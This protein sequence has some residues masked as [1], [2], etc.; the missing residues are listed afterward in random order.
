MSSNYLE[1]CARIFKALGHPSRLKMVECL[2]DRERSVCQIREIIGSDIS[3]VSIHLK[4]LK[5]AGILQNERRGTA[6]YYS[7]RMKCIPI[8]LLSVGNFA[9]QILE[10]QID[11]LHQVRGSS[12]R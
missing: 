9:G 2:L 4:I 11:S 12:L 5:E 7:L 8:W 1:I 3:T 6:V 10:E